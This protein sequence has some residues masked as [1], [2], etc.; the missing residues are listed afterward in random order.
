V[1]KNTLVTI[2]GSKITPAEASHVKLISS[3]NADGS[4]T[5]GIRSQNVDIEKSIVIYKS[6]GLDKVGK[7]TVLYFENA[8]KSLIEFRTSPVYENGFAAFE[9]PFVNANYKVALK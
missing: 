9:V 1:D 2:D 8:D 7:S 6:I 5:V 4:E 3:K